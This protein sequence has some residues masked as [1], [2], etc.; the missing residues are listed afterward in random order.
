[1]TDARIA[2]VTAGSAAE[3]ETIAGALVAEGLAA[4]VNI[5]PEVSS[6]YQWKGKTEKDTEVKMVIKTTAGCIEA[7]YHKKQTTGPQSPPLL[8]A[9]KLTFAEQYG[10]VEQPSS[11]LSPRAE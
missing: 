6:I 3:A 4:C 9:A 5:L 11:P 10:M 1:M 2:F 7:L 8:S